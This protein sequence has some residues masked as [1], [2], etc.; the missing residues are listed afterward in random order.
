MSRRD[1]PDSE[2]PTIGHGRSLGE[3]ELTVHC[4]GLYCYHQAVKTFDELKLPDDMIFIHV[5]RYR[6]FVCSKCG[7]RNVKVM[8]VFPSAKG[9]PG[10]VDSQ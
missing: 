1:P 3:T 8:P 4:L 5:P 9:T 2:L 6:R 10:Y 7:S